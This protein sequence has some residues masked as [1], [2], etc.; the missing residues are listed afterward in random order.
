M[1]V[2]NCSLF[3]NCV[4]VYCVPILLLFAVLTARLEIKPINPFVFTAAHRTN[5]STHA[6]ICN[7]KKY[8]QTQYTY[9]GYF[10][11]YGDTYNHF[12]DFASSPS[13][14]LGC[15]CSE[16]GQPLGVTVLCDEYCD[17]E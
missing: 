17:I 14:V 13:P 11:T 15:C 8:S 7:R 3:V 9:N 16:N 2:F 5:A 4:F 10:H 6:K 12:L 1:I